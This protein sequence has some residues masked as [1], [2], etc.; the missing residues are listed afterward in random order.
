[1]NSSSSSDRIDD[2]LANE[3][4]GHPPKSGF[5]TRRFR[6]EAFCCRDKIG[7]A[8]YNLPNRLHGLPVA[9]MVN[10]PFSSSIELSFVG[11]T[12]QGLSRSSAK[13]SEIA[14]DARPPIEDASRATL[15]PYLEGII[16]AAGGRRQLSLVTKLMSASQS[17]TE[18][19]A[20]LS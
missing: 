5:S 8:L 7:P 1:M 20:E 3:E 11:C 2:G 4:T 17:R 19:C 16:D 9:S 18:C 15:L 13:V 14:H 10:G 6:F 12:P